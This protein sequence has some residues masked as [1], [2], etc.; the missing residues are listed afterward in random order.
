MILVVGI[1]EAPVMIQDGATLEVPVI[2][3][4]CREVAVAA[5]AVAL[6]AGA[7]GPY[8]FYFNGQP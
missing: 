2:V 7:E 1:P 5:V 6:G 3:H 4:M 8:C